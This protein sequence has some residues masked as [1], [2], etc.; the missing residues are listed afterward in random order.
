MT[1]RVLSLLGNGLRLRCPRCGVGAL[2]RKPFSMWVN[3]QH[4]GLK[5]EREHGYFVGAMYIN[6]AATCAVALPGFFILDLLTA[7][8]IE[9]QLMIWVPFAV[10]F[11]LL[12]FHHSRSLW[13][14]LDHLF[15]PAANIYSVP[16]KKTQNP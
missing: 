14:V 16:P 13:L 9:Q 2:Y 7:I 1:G 3:C 15:N 11:P 5:F 10:I 12:F 6:Y 8:T 4:C